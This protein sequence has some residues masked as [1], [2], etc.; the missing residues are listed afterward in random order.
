MEAM[1]VPLKPG[2]TDAWSAWTDEL[3]GPRKTDF[4]DMNS[5][6]G[7][8]THATWLQQAPDGSQMVI[9]VLDGPGAATFMQKLATS[10]HEFD[11]WFRSNVEDVHPMDFSAPPP[12]APERR[13]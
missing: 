7:L 1:A 11:A 4:E 3:K 6:H 5:R 8:T 9:V 2:K 13:L 10:D 12:P